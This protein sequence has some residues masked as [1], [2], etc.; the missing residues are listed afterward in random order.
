MT[1]APSFKVHH[2]G[3]QISVSQPEWDQLHPEIAPLAFAKYLSLRLSTGVAF[4]EGCSY[5]LHILL[6]QAS[7]HDIGCPYLAYDVSV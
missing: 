4:N 1:S 2:A 7:Y 5:F 3:S 6:S